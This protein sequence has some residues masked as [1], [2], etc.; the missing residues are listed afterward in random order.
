MR[1]ATILLLLSGLLF[2]Q[3]RK[4]AAD[5]P[6]DLTHLS[7]EAGVDLEKKLLA[8][9]ATLSMTAL[10]KS[11]VVSLDAV[12]LDIRAVSV[13]RGETKQSAASSFHNTGTRLVIRLAQPAMRGEKL[14]VRVDYACKEPK[15][16]LN[17]FSPSK[18]EPEV[19]YQVWSQGET[20]STRHW[21]PIFDHPNERLTSELAI[22]VKD[23]LQVLSNGR[24]VSREGVIWHWSQV[25]DHAP[26]LITL[27]VGKFKVVKQA[28]RGK[29]V[30]YWVPP[31]RADDVMRSF[32]NTLRML[33]FFSNRIGVEYPWAKY[34][35]VVVEQFSFGGMENTSA[36]TL[37]ERTL[38]D[39]KAHVDYSSDG[40]VAHEL[41]HQWFG[42]L[43]TCR[44]WA[45]TW[46]NEGFA[47]YLQALWT[48][49][50][51]GDDEFRL[52]LWNKSKAAMR[53]GKKL[54]VVF[55]KY[56]G[57]WQQFDARAY[58]K[59]AWILHMIRRR[60]G[61]KAWWK[62]VNRYVVKNKHRSVETVDLRK[63]IE[64]STGISFERFFYDWTERPGHPVVS[65]QHRWM[66]KE[67]MM[68]VRVR[69]T[70][71]AEAWQF[72]LALEYVLESGKRFSVRH[73]VD[74]KDAR[75][76][77][78]LGARPNLVRVDPGQTVLMELSED[79]G[80]DW[81]VL[82]LRE[83]A[84]PIARIRAAQHFAKSR[85]DADRKV[86]VEA[87][88]REPFWGVQAEIAKAL[89]ASGGTRSRDGLL[90]GLSLQ[91]PKAR[92]SVVEAL[93]RFR[94]DA[95]V[96]SALGA[97]VRNGDA[98]Y[99]VEEAAIRAWAARR[100]QDAMPILARLLDRDSHRESIRNAALKGIGDQLDPKA[101][102]LLVGWTKRGKPRSCRRT[103]LQALGRM[104]RATLWDEATQAR[105]ARTVAGYLHGSESR[106]IKTA[107]IACLRDL[108]GVSE[109]AIEALQALAAHD[110]NDNVRKEA[111]KAIGKI[112]SGTPARLELQRLRAEL[113]KLR[114]ADRKL[115]ERM[116]KVERKVPVPVQG[117]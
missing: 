62:A 91:D 82:Q 74:T 47:T 110:L 66:A 112:R 17:F 16:G 61:D 3:D 76:Y 36:T 100:P 57:P 60:L 101:T 22:T 84:D 31:D 72:G 89:G 34:S 115:R 67:K 42:D 107:S 55:R 26:Y 18:A 78:P 15:A 93:A 4:F 44:D 11:T 38:H 99:S 58:P 21:I 49:Q 85:R 41:A 25:K 12:N 64:E 79:K 45:H 30:D 43:L 10:R 63:A 37:N 97:L 77:V 116:E 28:W 103:A 114:D 98:S 48:E 96:T 59:G 86:L 81:W 46:L 75:F 53:G 54:P 73:P 13:L 88:S 87:L 29:T 52:D 5:R 6:F 106:G 14:I 51:K 1:R 80:R 94:D 20:I 108:G 7:L 8:G 92:K 113:R 111:E 71:K 65:V 68:S 109:P 23:G 104:A 83:D 95:T 117:G 56:T 105:V 9:R 33:D 19:P 70:Q 40:L 24:L 35:Q 69:Q 90:Q 39:A 102:G 2:A 27:V 50:D 32:G